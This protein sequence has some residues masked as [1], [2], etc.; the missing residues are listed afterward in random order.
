MTLCQR[1]DQGNA[2]YKPAGSLFNPRGFEVSTIS[3][4][5]V[6]KAFIQTHHYSGTYPAARFRFGLH[7]PGGELVGVAVFSQPASN[8]VLAIAPGEGR[9]RVELGRLVILDGP[10]LGTNA[11]SWMVARCF[12][13]LAR[14]GG[15]EGVVSFSDPVPRTALDGTVTHRG[16]YGILYQASNALYTGR[17]DA[18]TLLLLPDGSTFNNRTAGKIRRRE[19]GWEYALRQ[20][21][22]AGAGDDYDGD[23]EAY[24]RRWLPRVTRR[25]R[26]SG[27]HRYVWGLSR[28]ARRELERRRAAKT[29]QTYD[30]PRQIDAA[31]PKAAISA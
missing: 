9:E 11:E 3:S 21:Q 13:L 30:F 7:R 31:V 22:A 5:K 16:H 18:R 10:D 24:L 28:G 20:L 4:D 2:R 19:R 23:G 1:W 15:I 17:G 26:H 12:E 29:L 25:I 27:N 14:D 8:A 6:A